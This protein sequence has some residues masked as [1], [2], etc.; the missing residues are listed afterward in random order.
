MHITSVPSDKITMSN[1]MEDIASTTSCSCPFTSAHGM[2]SRNEKSDSTPTTRRSSGKIR[3]I[4]KQSSYSSLPRDSPDGVDAR[5]SWNTDFSFSSKSS[6]VR[7]VKRRSWHLPDRDEPIRMSIVPKIKVLLING[8][9]KNKVERQDH[10]VKQL[11]SMSVKIEKLLYES[12]NSFEEY[13]NNA[14]LRQR[15][16]NCAMQLSRQRGSTR[17]SKVYKRAESD[18]TES[19]IHTDAS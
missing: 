8:S 5:H 1:Q 3:S 2:H 6:E 18:D 13:T 4:I 19:T 10:L 11:T 7:S 12:A 14:T 17:T 16:L 9:S 15:I